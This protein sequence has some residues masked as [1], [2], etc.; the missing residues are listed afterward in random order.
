MT[1][2]TMVP[3]PKAERSDG[4]I[5]T[6]VFDPI[7]AGDRFTFWT[8]YQVNPVNVGRRSQDAA[9]YDGPRKLAAVHREVT[10]FP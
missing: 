3:Q 2:N 9:L 8:Q 5:L 1:V 6:Y 4:G 10:V 7:P